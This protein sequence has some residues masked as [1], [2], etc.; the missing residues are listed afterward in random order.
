MERMLEGVRVLDLTQAYS[1]PFGCANLADHGAEVIKIEPIGGEQS[2]TWPP[3]KNG[4]SGYYAAINRNKKD[5]AIDLK[6]EEGKAVFEELVKTADVV[7]ENFKKGTFAKLGYDFEKLK[8]LNPKIIYAQLT[9]FGL[10]GPMSDRACYDIV[11]QAESG[12]MDMTGFADQPPVKVGP[13]IGDSVTG[14]YLA[15]GISMALYRRTITGQGYHLN[16]AML[17]SLFS[18]SEAFLSY[19]SWSGVEPKR[20]GNVVLDSIPWDLYPAKDGSYVV[21]AGTQRHWE[22][23]CHI[24]G[25]D[26]IIYLE[27]Y[28]D[29]EARGQHYYGDLLEK[30]EEAGKKM[31]LDELEEQFVA[32]GVPFGRVRSLT[33]AIHGEQIKARNMVWKV[34]DPGADEDLL[35][36]GQP[37]KFD[38]SPDEPQKASPTVGETTDEL[39][40]ELGYDDAK[41]AALK[42]SGA[43]E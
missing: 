20:S 17:D 12:F 24:L 26:D 18:L 43:V 2:R 23:F 10:N 41:I 11:A 13:S 28:K 33:D 32:A 7:A 42:E 21:G 5:I 6:S 34:H 35:M 39:L 27:E 14:V 15:M 29:F 3:F 38:V 8:E 25:L 19:Y 30:I 37:V 22:S 9:G 4:Y 1:G 16:V 31:T 36:P 40:K